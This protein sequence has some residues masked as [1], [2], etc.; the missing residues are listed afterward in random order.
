LSL[1]GTAN[2][3][4]VDLAASILAEEDSVV[5]IEEQVALRR[6]EDR[7]LCEVLDPYQDGFESQER[8]QQLVESAK[9]LLS[10]SPLNSRLPVPI[11][12]WINV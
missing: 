5:L 6:V 4:R 9:T 11:L 8:F 7:I 2:E 12:D 3:S 1:S 10:A